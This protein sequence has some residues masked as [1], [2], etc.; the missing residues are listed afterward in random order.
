[1]G[2]YLPQRACHDHNN[3]AVPLAQL[4]IIST[5]SAPIYG[6]SL[7]LNVKQTVERCLTSS[8]DT[9]GAAE[10]LEEV[11]KECGAAQ[12]HTRIPCPRD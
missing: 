1:M 9:A 8:V 12:A 7:S 5:L 6:G 10:E 11:C 3:R 4:L 2:G